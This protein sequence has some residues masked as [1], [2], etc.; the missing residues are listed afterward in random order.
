MVNWLARARSNPARNAASSS[1]DF[2]SVDRLA[3]AAA[4]AAIRRR[5]Q[6]LLS[7]G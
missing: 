7:D 4:A 2:G 3:D 5:S 1:I 6:I